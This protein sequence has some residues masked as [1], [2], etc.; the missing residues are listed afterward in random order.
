MAN[1]SFFETLTQYRLRVEKDGKDVVNV[2]SIFAL[3]GLL[4]APKLSITGLIAA[5]L[6]GLKVH[7]ESEDG[8]AVDMEEAVRKAAEAVKE[9][10][11]STTK[12]IKEEMDKAWEAVSSD[13]PEEDVTEDAEENEEAPEEKDVS[14]D[15]IVEELK[16]HEENDTPA[17]EVKPDD[18]DKA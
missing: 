10:V 7:L 17:I 16:A 3:P 9:S 6:L 1:K 4:M 12:T 8:E 11:V 15:D 2:S 18:S 13:Y 14:N 5:P